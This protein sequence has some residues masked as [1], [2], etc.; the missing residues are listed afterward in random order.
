MSSKLT[1]LADL[2]PLALT[3]E[4]YVVRPSL[5][6]AGSRSS[7]LSSLRALILAGVPQNI[8]V[9][10]STVNSA[11]V[12]P[13]VLHT[14]SLPANSLATNGD[15]LSLWYAGGFAAVNRDKWVQ[16]QFDGTSYE[17]GG[18][19]DFD[20]NTGWAMAARITRTDAT[21]VT[22]SH[23]LMQNLLEITA[24]NVATSL[25]AGGAIIS[26]DSN[27]AVANLNSNAITMRVRSVVAAGA[28]AGDVFQNLSIIEL[29]QH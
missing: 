24:A 18:V 10:T 27:F 21:H 2:S 7:L 13:D 8:E 14:F 16:A 11:G 5:G 12:G 25:N 26:R 15:Y 6:A 19:F 4:M 28:A 1:A 9:N 17:G 3:D 29:C 23:I 22:V 20:L